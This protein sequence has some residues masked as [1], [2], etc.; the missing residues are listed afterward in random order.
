MTDTKYESEALSAVVE[1]VCHHLMHGTTTVIGTLAALS[2]MTA[3]RDPYTVG[4]EVRVGL[5][6]AAISVR[7][8]LDDSM[9]DLI[10]LG[11]E[12][13]D[14][15]KC[16]VPIEILVFPGKINA[17]QFDLVKRHTIIGAEILSRAGLPWQLAD[18]AL[19]HHERLDGS[20]YPYGLVGDEI[21]LPARVVAVADVI[22]AI[23]QHRPYRAAVG[24][25][26]AVNVV[27]AGAG[28]L[29]DAAVV[30]AC[31]AVL[32]DG[33]AFQGDALPLAG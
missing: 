9:V 20:G 2:H 30:R 27:R 22:E 31:L 33:F 29:F 11:G 1:D 6:A 18:V 14:I 17:Q 13:H 8:G 5:L 25:D 3:V 32:E 12:V 7:L 26:Q 19:Q 16:A 23:S 10:R 4:H 24:L 21:I 15:G 28:V